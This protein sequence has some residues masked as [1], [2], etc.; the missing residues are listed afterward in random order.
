MATESSLVFVDGEMNYD[1][2][3]IVDWLTLPLSSTELV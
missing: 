3:V 2:V 1:Y